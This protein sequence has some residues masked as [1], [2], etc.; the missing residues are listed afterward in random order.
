MPCMPNSRSHYHTMKWITSKEN[1]QYRELRQLAAS[2]NAR[3]K[4]KYAL[5]DGIHLCQSYL[6][7]GGIPVLCAMSESSQQHPEVAAIVARCQDISTPCIL[8]ADSLYKPLSQVENGIDILFVIPKPITDTYPELKQA[9][10]L[11]D[12]IQDQGNLGSILRSAAAAGI[13][14]VYCNKGTASIWSPRVLRA[15]MGA[16]F[17]L[18]LYEDVPLESLIKSAR[19]PV[20]ATIPRAEKTIYDVDLK[21]ASAWLLG[22]EGQGISET[23]LKLASMHLA[24]PQPGFVESI[25]VAAS[26][27]VC[28][29]EQVRQRL[30]N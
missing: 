25:N 22:H 9:A 5:L 6:E 28:F 14:Q 1:V 2:A 17:L 4:S 30:S 21:G 7:Y 24:V 12:R 10:V 16:H 29:F 8:L 27:A 11:L 19:I 3:R 26:A 20:I 23:L 18:E 15:G 13:R